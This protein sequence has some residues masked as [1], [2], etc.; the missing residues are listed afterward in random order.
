MPVLTAPYGSH[1]TKTVCMGIFKFVWVR[2]G[3]QSTMPKTSLR[4]AET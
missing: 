2:E 3:E 1:H 4:Y